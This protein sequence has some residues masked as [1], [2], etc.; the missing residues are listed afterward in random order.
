[1]WC[2]TCVL[3]GGRTCGTY[4]SSG[5]RKQSWVVAQGQGASSVEVRKE[6]ILGRCL[7]SLRTGERQGASTEKPCRPGAE[8]WCLGGGDG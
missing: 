3:R 5:G 6:T 1:M 8:R 4:R 7:S 2:R